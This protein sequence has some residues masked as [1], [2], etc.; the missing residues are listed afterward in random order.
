M[1]EKRENKGKKVKGE[2][3]QGG[4]NVEGLGLP[5]H[6]G[7]ALKTRMWSQP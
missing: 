6:L 1:R 3:W 2:D 7:D 5:E 4:Q